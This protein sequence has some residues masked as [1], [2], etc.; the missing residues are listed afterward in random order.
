MQY[1]RFSLEAPTHRPQEKGLESGTGKS[2]SENEG[3]VLPLAWPM[4]K[5][6]R[7]GRGGGVA[8]QSTHLD[9]LCLSSLLKV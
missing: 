2:A 6:N 8:S 7:G 5:E 1:S 9:N 4:G 3:W